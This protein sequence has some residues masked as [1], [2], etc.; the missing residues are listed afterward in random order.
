MARIGFRSTTVADESAIRALLLQAHGA[1]V[2]HP[3]FESRNLFWKYWEPRTDWPGSRSYVLT[4]DGEIIAHAAVVPGVCSCGERRLRLLHVID[5]AARAEARGAGNTLMRHIGTLGDAIITSDGD[6]A[7]L[8]LLPLMG[9]SQSS[10]RVMLYAR[11]LRPLLYLG[12]AERP[13]WRLAARTV[14]NALWAL[15]APTGEPAQRTWSARQLAAAEVASAAIPWPVARNGTAV[16]E[17]SAAV[18]SYWLQC[19]AAPMQLYLL[20]NGSAARGYMVLAFAP[21]Q[22]RLA[23]CWLD[24]EA[25]DAWEALVHL[26]VHAALR[27]EGVAEIAAMCSEPLLSGALERCGFHARAARPLYA[28]A[29]DGVALPRGGIR[30]QMLDDDAAYRHNGARL[31]WA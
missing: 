2:A 22:A 18:M 12:G 19:P 9:F 16:L 17:R 8:R 15:R 4:R 13:R 27:H 1:S 5:W 23:D 26:A 24:T 10:T 11:P 29:A 3:M 25:P 7:A 14:R 28:R 6:E 31:F 21:G 20:E 30:I